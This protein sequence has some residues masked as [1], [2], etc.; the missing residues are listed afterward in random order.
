LRLRNHAIGHRVRHR[1]VPVGVPL[2]EA[3][4]HTHLRPSPGSFA[5][6]AVALWEEQHG[7]FTGEEMNE[8]RRS[9]RAQFRT[10]LTVRRP[11]SAPLSTTPPF[12]WPPIET[13]GGR[14]LNTG[15]DWN[16]ALFHWFLRL[17]S[18]S[19]GPRNKP[20]SGAS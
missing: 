16:L 10:T 18:R 15:S 4:E 12:S 1:R 19:A 17:W 8:A 14:R 9:V 2:A 20:N 11:A 5:T 7:R 3:E 6:S 13:S